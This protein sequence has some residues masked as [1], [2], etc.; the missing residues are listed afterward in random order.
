MCDT[1][2]SQKSEILDLLLCGEEHTVYIDIHDICEIPVFVI[3][4]FAD[5]CRSG[6]GDEHINLVGRFRNLGCCF[7]AFRH[8]GE[9]G[10]DGN[11]FCMRVLIWRFQVIECRHGFEKTRFRSSDYVDFLTATLYESL[12]RSFQ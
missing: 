2:W 9:V 7:L 6:I 11:S 8:Y 3:V 5:E 1:G 10:D 12:C 4:K